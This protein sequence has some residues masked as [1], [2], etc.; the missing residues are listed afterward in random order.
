MQDN[1]GRFELTL[2]E[3][4]AALRAAE[5]R[6]A[7]L[8]LAA[9]MTERLA[10]AGSFQMAWDTMHVTWSENNLRLFG[11][12]EEEF[13]KN[14]TSITEFIHPEDRASF[15]RTMEHVIATREPYSH[16]HRIIRPDGEIRHIR[17][18]AETAGGP[19]GNLF[20]A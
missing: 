10:N 6:I 14:Y 11:L 15:D 16:R 7:Q 19:T 12:T 1:T 17:E 20:L 8:E 5:D 9:A 18:V 3:A 4:L 2:D 13:G